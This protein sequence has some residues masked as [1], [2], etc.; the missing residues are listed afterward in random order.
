MPSPATEPDI[1]SVLARAARERPS[2]PRAWLGHGLP[3]A[4]Q[5]QVMQPEDHSSTDIAFVEVETVS[6]AGVAARIGVPSLLRCPVVG[7]SDASYD[8]LGLL[9]QPHDEDGVTLTR[10]ICPVAVFDFGPTGLIVREIQRGLTAAGLQQKLPVTLWA[11]PDLK[12]L[13]TP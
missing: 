1:A 8:R 10:L 2:P 6:P 13:G 7:L 9:I 3:Q 5:D 12:E 11:G 4:L